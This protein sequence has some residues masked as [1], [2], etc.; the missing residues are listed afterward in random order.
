MI[1]R[2]TVLAALGAAA[3]GL[4]TAALGTAVGCRRDAAGRRRAL[5]PIG[6]QLYTVRAEME[7]DFDGALQQVRRIG[8]DEVEFAGYFGRSP[9]QV[10]DALARHGLAAPAAHVG[11]ADMES[12][13]NRTL[14]AASAIGH[15]WLVLPWIDAERRRTLED[16]RRLAAL[17]S[18]AGEAARAA[19]IRVAY[20]NHD[21]EFAPLAGTLPFDLLLAETAPGLVAFEL[22]VYW[23]VKAGGDPVAWLESHPARFELLHLKDTA[24]PPDHAM[25]DVGSGLIGWPRLL[26]AARAAGVSHMFVEH[27]EPADA[28]ASLRSSYAYL[29][30]VEGNGLTRS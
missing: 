9:R 24:G 18:R 22:D 20:H 3:A 7:R 30:S 8:Y 21:Y 13:W 28:V 16:W 14:A 2:R 5:A 19:G 6:A 27:D 4:G 12:K 25:M 17:L 29:R 15:A 23:M 26:S 10:R 11:L 1:G